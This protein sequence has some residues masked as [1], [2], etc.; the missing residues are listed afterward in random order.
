MTKFFFTLIFAF[1]INA[2]LIFAIETDVFDASI[3]KTVGKSPIKI[4]KLDDSEKIHIF[5]AGE[6]L[7]YND[8]LDE[9][10]EKPSWWVADSKDSDP[11]KVMDFDIFFK[12]RPFRPGIDKSSGIMYIPFVGKIMSVD[13]QNE[14][15]DDSDVA[16]ITAE[17]IDF[18]GGHLLLTISNGPN[19]RGRLDVF[20][21][22]T[23]KV[24]Q[25][26]NGGINM[27]DCR[28]YQ[29][30][31]GISIAMINQG[32]FGT[33]NST[34][35]YGAINH[36]FDF[37]LEDSVVVGDAV[38]HIIYDNGK[39]YAT[40]TMSH[41]IAVIDVN[42]HEIEFWHTGTNSWHGPRESLVKDGRLYV[43]TYSG[44]VRVFDL[45]NGNLLQIYDGEAYT[46]VENI[47]FIDDNTFVTAIPYN[48]IYSPINSYKIWN[49]RKNE[50]VDLIKDIKVGTA[51]L[52]VMID[53]STQIIHV[54][55]LGND[56]N[57]NGT[58]E[59]GEEAASWWTI[60]QTDNNLI[61]EQQT[62]LD[63]SDLK[64]P[65][66]P[67]LDLENRIIYLPAL[68]FIKSYD[69]D[70][71]TL[72]DNNIAELDAIS[73]DIAGTHLLAAVNHPDG[74]DSVY[75]INL[76]NNQILQ[77]V[78]AG[79]KVGDVKYFSSIIDGN[80]NPVI[81]LA[82]ITGEENSFY[83]KLMWGPIKH[84][85][86]FTLDNSIE[87]NLIDSRIVAY[88]NYIAVA[89][90][91]TGEVIVVET[92]ENDE[93]R[94]NAGTMSNFG[95]TVLA[96]TNS[97]LGI[98]MSTYYGDLRPLSID[99][100]QFG[101]SLNFNEFLPV[102]STIS[103][104]DINI[105]DESKLLFAASELFNGDQFNNIVKVFADKTTSVKEYNSGNI[106]NIKI[107]P[108]PANEFIN[109]E[110]EL[111]DENDLLHAEILS[112][113]GKVISQIKLNSGKYINHTFDLKG[114]NLTNGTYILR[115]ID[116]NEVKSIPFII[117]K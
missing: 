33:E 56:I 10:D 86:E 32:E 27:V 3:D 4:I 66:R 41:K 44:D 55:C 6:D 73:L 12:Y 115:I 95:P 76:Q 96:N 113:E 68:G 71:Y 75:V 20:N 112:I 99:E 22:Q 67:A 34:V 17:S 104:M 1:A 65:F 98:V 40:I 106:A 2:Q 92:S 9:G 111:R 24:L 37:E 78:Y 51:P 11:R 49:K 81:S 60:K 57:E 88:G 50:L 18:A 84:T 117:V 14:S 7:N 101:Y 77:K 42:T 46:K 110:T 43:T 90:S 13:L 45:L 108:N 19:E 103:T 52:H 80:P 74:A 64:I 8:T 105:N 36:M 21:L 63:F 30:E 94:I 82:I 48:F 5:C 38:N 79:E 16:N 116:G 89:S 69:I 102:G 15:M 62:E 54:F 58:L 26:I 91:F 53:K 72:L 59:Q 70:N 61:A 35:Y 93:Q 97:D 100:Q 107:Y 31:S 87:S 109:I 85:E 25:S 83:S 28:Y 39:L 23:S 29:G 47:E 114:L